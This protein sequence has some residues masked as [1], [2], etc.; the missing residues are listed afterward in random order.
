MKRTNILFI[1][2]SIFLQSAVALG[3]PSA[4]LTGKVTNKE[5]R[6]PL[7]G[8]SVLIV[9]T[10]YGAST[11]K[12]GAYLIQNLPVGQYTVTARYVGYSSQSK[13]IELIAEQ[14]RQLD[15]MLEETALPGQTIVVTASLGHERETPATFS[16]LTAQTIREQ[17]TVQDLPALLSQLPS[18]TYYSESGNSIGYN[19]ISIRGFDQRRLA[20]MINGIPQ[21]DPEDH[22][23]YWVDFPDLTANL[24][25][26]Q[27]QRGAGSAFYGPPAVGGSV[28]LLTTSFTGQ[29]QVNVFAGYGSYN[30]RKYSASMSSG[31]IDNQYAIYGRLAKIK[32]SGYRERSWVDFDSYFLGAVRYDENM[33]TQLNFY[34]G[35]IADHLAYYG[36]PKSYI[37]DRNLRKANFIARDEEIENFSQPHYELLH[38]WRLNDKLTLNNSLFFVSG[39]GYYDYDGSWADTSYFR[40]TA[41]NGFQLTSNPQNALIRAFVDNKQYG[42]LPRMTL[43]HE[44]GE[45]TAGAEVRLHRS[46]HWGRIQWA[47]N[48]SPE[49]PEDFHYYEY[50]GKKDIVSLYGQELYKLQPD[51]TLMFNLQYVYNR[52]RLYDEKFLGTDFSVP[53]HFLNPRIGLN[54]NITSEWNAY[55]SLSR[56]S[57]EPRLKNLY[58]AG[59]SSGGQTPQFET[60]AD[61]SYDFDRPL[62][63]PEKL[64]DI[65]LGLSYA[66]PVVRFGVN[67]FWMDFHDEIIKKGGLDRFGQP[68]TGNAARTRHQGIEITASARLVEG[69]EFIGNLSL[70]KNE[71]RS[72][73]NFLKLQNLATGK[74]EIVGVT[75]DGNSIAGFP[76]LIANGRLTYRLDDLTASL[77]AQYVGEQF[78]DN[79]GEMDVAVVGGKRYQLKTYDNRVDPYLVVNFTASHRFGD[80]PG[81]SGL[82][83]KLQVNNLFNKLYAMY[84]SGEEFFPAA[85][86]NAFLGISVN[87]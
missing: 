28:N 25:S 17:Y 80:V 49:V 29:R 21:N 87:L 24:G 56:T 18:T 5:T 85:E 23:V 78:T 48:I 53:Y 82:E 68:R 45:L 14:E 44:N 9:G 83:L 57:R 15:F 63:V 37:G 1:A 36:I 7:A 27:V 3:Q 19:Y 33:T 81:L 54:Y 50:R 46:Y 65:E 71:L 58:D 43:R 32:S 16:N 13:S 76:D 42:W 59:E 74:K 26:I 41:A 72:Y 2:M 31:L 34:G 47:Q 12:N 70:S 40:L 69:F 4:T 73:T 75:L 39:E 11:D 30:T 61:G 62:V 52:Y 77:S 51:L 64:N 6:A 10:S 66:S 84:G 38:E 79:F 60:R 35:P 67:L 55:V 20:V 86:R 8:A 22:N